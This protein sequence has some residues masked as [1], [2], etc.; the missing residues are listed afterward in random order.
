[1]SITTGPGRPVR[2]IWKAFFTVTV[3]SLMSVTRKLC[4]T[5]GRDTPTMSISWNASEPMAGEPTWPE[6]TTSGIESEYAVAMPVM[7]VPS[8]AVA[9][10]SGMPPTRPSASDT[11]MIEM[12]GWIL[13]FEI[14]TIINT[15]AQTNAMMS[16]IPVMDPASFWRKNGRTHSIS[17]AFP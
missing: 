12:N 3:R 13:S 1:M 11:S 17:S 9:L 6:I 4:F 16:G 10:T 8:S 15:I 5:H 2:A 14:I 7:A